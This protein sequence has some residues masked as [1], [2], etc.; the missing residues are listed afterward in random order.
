MNYQ[1]K[2]LQKLGGIS[3]LYGA[4]A[5]LIAIVFFLFVVDYPSVT[6]PLDK[7]E[8]IASNKALFTFMYLIAYVIFGFVLII[9]SLAL[10][11]KL[12]STEQNI[13]KIATAFGIVWAT[14]LIGS[15]MIFNTG[16]KVVVDLYSTDPDQAVNVWLGIEAVSLGLGFAYGEILGGL[17]ILMV[18]IIALKGSIFKKGL[19]YLGIFIGLVGIIS[20]IPILNAIT[21]VFGILLIVWFIWLG[22]LLLKNST[23]L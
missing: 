1:T 6:E 13:M 15:G 11:E 12:K 18:S 7:I 22:I 8:L 14:L 19:N 5:F 10:H 9:L 20:I 3:A 16:I 21:G 2:N 17:W 23:S 4:T